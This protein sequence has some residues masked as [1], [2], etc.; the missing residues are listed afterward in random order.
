MDSKYSPVQVSIADLGKRITA[1]DF[2]VSAVEFGSVRVEEEMRLVEI[3]KQKPVRGIARSTVAS[4]GQRAALE[5][6]RH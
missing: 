5:V 6:R 4:A 1:L 3:A 2:K